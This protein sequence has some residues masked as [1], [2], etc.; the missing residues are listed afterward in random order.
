M[1]A[2][3]SSLLHDHHSPL[4]SSQMRVDMALERAEA[5]LSDAVST[6]AWNAYSG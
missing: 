2:D 6:T 4:R 3:S 5:E 1:I